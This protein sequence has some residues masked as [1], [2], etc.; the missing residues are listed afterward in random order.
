MLEGCLYAGNGHIAIR[1]TSGRWMASDFEPPAELFRRKVGSLPWESVPGD[2]PEWIPLDD[3]R[4]TIYR[5]APVSIWTEQNKR[6]ATPVVKIAGQH[7]IRLSHLQLIAR[8]PRCEVY[9]G[10][11]TR[12]DPLFFRYNGGAVIVPTDKS[13]TTASLALFTPCIDTLSGKSVERT[14]HRQT[15]SGGHLKG[16]PPA[17]PSDD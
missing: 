1:A 10:P 8:L 13:L 3:G 9:A 12:H 4:G 17:T 16:W 6:S 15:F 11:V 5:Y 7:L 2:S 14:K